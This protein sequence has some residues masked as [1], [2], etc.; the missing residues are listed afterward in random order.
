MFF[1]QARTQIRVLS[2]ASTYIYVLSQASTYIYVLSQA[3]TQIHVLS[4]ASTYIYVL[5]QAR[6][7]IST[8]FCYLLLSVVK[9]VLVLRSGLFDDW[10][11]C[12][13]WFFKILYTLNIFFD[14]KNVQLPNIQS[15]LLKYYTHKISSLTLRTHRIKR[16]V[17]HAHS[18][19][20]TLC[21]YSYLISAL[22]EINTGFFN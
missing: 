21:V 10:C 19:I 6:T 5:S 17:L 20:I 2:Q 12:Q 18:A 11:N 22:S 15:W 1:F 8:N 9:F 16:H 13:T 7:Y 3:R 4:Q 14:I